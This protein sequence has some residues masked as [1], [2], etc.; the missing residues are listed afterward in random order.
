LFSKYIFFSPLQQ[1]FKGKMVEM[2]KCVHIRFFIKAQNKIKNGVLPIKSIFP[3]ASGI[4]MESDKKKMIMGPTFGA[5]CS[6]ITAKGSSSGC[7]TRVI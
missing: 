5:T 3:R 7:K 1:H 6:I 2:Y 4:T